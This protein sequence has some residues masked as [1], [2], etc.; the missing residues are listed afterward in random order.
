MEQ[1]R[2]L[3]QKHL[4]L[5]MGSVSAPMCLLFVPSNIAGTALSLALFLMLGL[6]IDRQYGKIFFTNTKTASRSGTIVVMAFS[7]AILGYAFYARWTPSGSAAMIAGKFGVPV[8]M[9]VGPLAFLR[10][11]A[12]VWCMWSMSK[13]LHNAEA[14]PEGTYLQDPSS[15]S[16]QIEFATNKMDKNDWLLCAAIALGGAI[17]LCNTC[18]F[19]GKNPDVDSSVFL[20][21]GREMLRGKIPYA[22]LFDHKG[23]ILYFLQCIGSL[24]SLPET[25]SGVWLIELVSLFVTVIFMYK[26]VRLLTASK[27][28]CFLVPLIIVFTYANV[29][30]CGGNFTEEYAMPWIA[31]TVYVCLKFFMTLRYQA[32]EIVA[33]GAGCAI[34]AFLRVNMIGIWIAFTPLVVFVLFKE[35]RI[36]EILPCIGCF[37]GGLAAVCVPLGVYFALTDSL[38]SMIEYYIYFNMDYVGS[39]ASVIN[40]LNAALSLGSGV[41]IVAIIFAAMAYKRVMIKNRIIFWINIWGFVVSLLFAAMSGQA[42]DHYGLI[43]VP[44]LVIPVWCT[45]QAVVSCIEQTDALQENA[46]IGQ[47]FRSRWKTVAAFLII[48][49]AVLGMVAQLIVTDSSGPVVEYLL[50]ETDEA[51]DVLLVGM[52]VS[53]YLES[54]RKTD[55]K[56]FYHIPILNIS[57]ALCE[58]FLEELDRDP[59]DYILL[60]SDRYITDKLKERLDQWCQEGV[61]ACEDHNFFVVYRHQNPLGSA[62]V[63]ESKNSESLIISRHSK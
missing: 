48:C 18:P 23:V 53:Y 33:L 25:Y 27:V 52:P 62:Q 20:Y 15:R 50:E 57:N 30:Y 46:G 26:T 6:R 58:E 2:K 41:H 36:K 43:L 61:Y 11:F 28:V 1:L 4:L 16:G 39:G 14:D 63:A 31:V 12:A 47:L 3:N 8:W 13:L 49:P 44:L 34:V 60:Y 35:R 51:D 38:N 29:F 5:I 56:F 9:I 37:I 19:T 45:V 7:A 21:I 55:N 59:S 40:Q 10:A 17:A 54:H 24:L 32:V 42:Y 22:D